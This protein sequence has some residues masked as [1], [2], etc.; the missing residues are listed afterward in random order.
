MSSHLHIVPLHDLPIDYVTDKIAPGWYV[1]CGKTL[2]KYQEACEDWKEMCSLTADTPADLD[3]KIV[4]NMRM[5]LKGPVR[6]CMDANKKPP[7]APAPAA[8]TAA[9][10]TDPPPAGPTAA[11]TPAATTTPAAAT[12]TTRRVGLRLIR[13]AGSLWPAKAT[14]AATRILLLCG[15]WLRLCLVFLLGFLG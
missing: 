15:I 6:E 13:R 10:G 11:T 4:T 1:G 5:R 3:K 8:P 12:T 9:T 14:T 2:D 7:T